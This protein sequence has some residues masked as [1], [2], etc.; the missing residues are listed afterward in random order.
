MR[1]DS[2]VRPQ[3]QLPAGLDR[4]GFT[5]VTALAA[6]VSPKRLRSSDLDTPFRGVRAAHDATDSV[7]ALCRAFA[8]RMP[9]HQGF[10]HLTAVRLFALPEPHRLHADTRLHVSAIAP[11]RAPRMR[12]I[13]GYSLAPQR[14][15]VEGTLLVHD[16]LRVVSPVDTWCQMAA[17]LTVDELVT[18]G[19]ALVRRQRPLATIGALDA[20]LARYSGA[21]GCTKLV[22]ALPL[23]RPGTDSAKETELRLAIVRSGLPEP[24]VNTTIYDSLG[25]PIARGDLVFREYKVLVEYDGEHHRLDLRQY[26]ND[27]D[28]NERLAEAEWRTIHFNRT[29]RAARQTAAL[30]SLRRALCARGWTPP[31]E[32]AASARPAHADRFRRDGS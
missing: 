22:Q 14:A 2:G 7:H 21:R 15:A 29:H 28:R 24:E 8:S 4:A 17:Q 18:L 1:K 6:G 10:S 5:V 20:V 26:A 13:R 25:L 3:Q 9:R 12:G 16:G 27:V 32:S 19:D 31:R 30:A 11:H 23:I